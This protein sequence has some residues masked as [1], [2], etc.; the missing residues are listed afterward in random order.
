M[1]V[2]RVIFSVFISIRSL[3][4]NKSEL[5]RKLKPVFFFLDLQLGSPNLV[6]KFLK[7]RG[8]TS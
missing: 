4:A 3:D 6:G 2:E 8:S 7:E 5:Q 1:L